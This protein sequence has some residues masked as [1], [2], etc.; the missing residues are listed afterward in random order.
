MD[1]KKLYKIAA[2]HY[3]EKGELYIARHYAILGDDLKFLAWQIYGES[4]YTGFSN[5][6][7][8]SAYVSG[9]GSYIDM[10]ST[11]AYG[12]Y[13]Y[14]NISAVWYHYLTGN[15]LKMTEALDRLYASLKR[16]AILHPEFLERSEER[17]VG[18]E[19]TG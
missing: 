1:P 5:N 3:S 10:L 4:Q 13:P 9:V 8:I 19:C 6:R 18:K 12:K 17:R 14:L 15:V 2:R 7:S 11:E 16:I